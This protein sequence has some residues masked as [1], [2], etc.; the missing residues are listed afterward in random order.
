VLLRLKKF[1]NSTG[2]YAALA[3]ATAKVLISGARRSAWIPR[4]F[5][6]AI[7]TASSAESRVTGPVWAAA[8]PTGGTAGA[9]V[10][11]VA[12]VCPEANTSRPEPNKT[13]ARTA[14]D[15]QAERAQNIDFKGITCISNGRCGSKPVQ[16]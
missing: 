4:L 8:A 1:E 6:S 11:R 16:R 12:G 7:R 9:V 10:C 13:S 15:K 5:S 3:P 2:A 14:N